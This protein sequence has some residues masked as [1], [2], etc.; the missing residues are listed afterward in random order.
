MFNRAPIRMPTS[1][2]NFPH[3][4]HQ[5]CESGSV[6]NLLNFYDLHLSEAMVFGIGAGLFFAYVPFAKIMDGPFLTFRFFPGKVFKT[7]AKNLGVDY[8]LKTFSS[9]AKAK[10]ALDEKIAEGIP[11]GLVTN[12][13]HLSYMPEMFRL[14]FNFHNLIVLE[15][16]ANKYRV[17]DSILEVTTDLDEDV[18]Q[19]ARFDKG[20]STNPKGKLY[21]IKSTP[22]QLSLA[23]AVE[24]GIATTAKRMLFSLN[25]IGGLASMKRLAKTLRKYPEKHSREQGAQLLLHIVR[26]QEILG[27]GG[28]GF[29]SMYA[30][31]LQ[32]ASEH[33]KSKSLESF[34]QR[35]LA[36]ADEW[37]NFALIA[38]KS[39]KKSNSD[40]KASFAD[41]GD[42]L[43]ALAEKETAFFKEIKKLKLS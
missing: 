8:E 38:A 43:M 35:M 16:K 19:K 21:W 7:A 13:F 42:R 11:V 10:T 37:R 1:I 5:H 14:P 2:E 27:T 29:R 17:S 15:K 32:E 20:S 4:A 34:A 40:P 22:S 26:L 23:R 9:P 31:F 25:P 12:M 6:S 3:R 36:I 39:A 33:L 18:L 28:A 30:Q 41:L 24:N